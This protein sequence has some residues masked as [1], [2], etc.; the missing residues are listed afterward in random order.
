[1]KSR[2]PKR[3][4]LVLGVSEGLSY[5]ADSYSTWDEPAVERVSLLAS[6]VPLTSFVSF[7]GI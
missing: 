3:S 4:L 6:V 1:M 5:L 7:A 2:A